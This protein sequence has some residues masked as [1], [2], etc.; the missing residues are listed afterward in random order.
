VTNI[1]QP[2]DLEENRG[3]LQNG[4][5]CNQI[6]TADL[7]RTS[8][9]PMVSLSLRLCKVETLPPVVHEG[10]VLKISVQVEVDSIRITEHKTKTSFFRIVEVVLFA[11]VDIG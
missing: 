10:V 1:K 6:E 9:P 7:L 11:H 8:E 4:T 5:F 3:E 2:V